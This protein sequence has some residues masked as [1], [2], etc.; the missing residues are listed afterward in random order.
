M[1]L[2]WS[3][4]LQYGITD[5]INVAILWALLGSMI[6]SSA[7]LFLAGLQAL[8]GALKLFS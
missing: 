2:L 7:L 5:L 1:A 4:S 6:V 3:C 8:L